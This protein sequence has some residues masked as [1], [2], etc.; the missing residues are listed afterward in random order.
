[1]GLCAQLVR[2][3]SV[4]YG[5]RRTFGGKVFSRPLHRPGRLAGRLLGWMAVSLW[6]GER[7]LVGSWAS[8]EDL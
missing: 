6:G 5:A 1:M 4:T 8:G 3:V 2:D 7:S